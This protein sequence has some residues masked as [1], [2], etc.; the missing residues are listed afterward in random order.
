MIEK[1]FMSKKE[2]KKEKKKLVKEVEMGLKS[3]RSEP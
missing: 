1:T 2:K 3:I